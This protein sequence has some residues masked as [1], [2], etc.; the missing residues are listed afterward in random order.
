MRFKTIDDFKFDGKVA[1]VRVDLN[2]EVDEKTKKV[3]PGGRM[4]AHAQTVVE[5]SRRNAKVVLLAHQ[6]R[7]GEYDFLPL[8]QHAELLSEKV[9][10]HIRFVH[11]NLLR[12]S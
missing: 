12:E 10:M 9:A 3:T 7:K 1:L 8:E 6:G 4:D 2:S 5:M 11:G